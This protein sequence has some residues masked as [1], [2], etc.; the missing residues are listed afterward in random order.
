MTFGSREGSARAENNFAL[1]RALELL[2]FGWRLSARRAANNT[3]TVRR[4]AEK[5]TL[6]KQNRSSSAKFSDGTDDHENERGT[7]ECPRK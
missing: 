4:L 7:I 3:R 1:L 5:P 6:N 2:I